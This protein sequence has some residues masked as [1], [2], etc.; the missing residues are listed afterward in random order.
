MGTV[1]VT[2][3]VGDLQ[4]HQ[5]REVPTEV[6]TGATYSAIPRTVLEEL[7]VRV[8]DTLPTKLADGSEAPADMGYALLRVQGRELPTI[9]LF[10][11]EREPAL[12][13]VTT[14]ELA[15]LGVDPLNGELIPVQ[16]KRY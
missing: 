6:D 15:R 14:L 5:F 12:L 3:E 2:I 13:G 4:G 16:A 11:E 10:A 7:G 1:T 9:V 8:M